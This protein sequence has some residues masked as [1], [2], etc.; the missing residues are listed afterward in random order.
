MWGFAMKILQFPTFFKLKIMSSELW[1]TDSLSLLKWDTVHN[2]HNAKVIQSLNEVCSI[3]KLIVQLE[4]YQV[5]QHLPY[6]K[7]FQ[8]QNMWTYT[9]FMQESIFV[10]HLIVYW[11]IKFDIL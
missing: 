11:T 7:C 1:N 6:I 9:P 3:F 2:L 10:Q 8:K 5:V 4:N